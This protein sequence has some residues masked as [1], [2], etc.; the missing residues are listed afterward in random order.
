MKPCRLRKQKNLRV[1]SCSQLPFISQTPEIHSLRTAHSSWKFPLYW[2]KF[3]LLVTFYLPS[4]PSNETIPFHKRTLYG[5]EHPWVPSFYGQALFIFCIC[6]VFSGQ[7][8]PAFYAIVFIDMV[9]S[10][11]RMASFSNTETADRG[12][13]YSALCLNR[14]WST[15]FVLTI[16]QYLEYAAHGFSKW[17]NGMDWVLILS[18]AARCWIMNLLQTNRQIPTVGSGRH[19][20]LSAQV[21]FHSLSCMLTEPEFCL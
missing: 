6:T 9:C 4:I 5:L 10:E 16:C 8:P 2:A 18:T 17:D 13:T 15:V 19:Y 20:Q 14:H 1:L 11:L 3:C 12:L 21:S 7:S